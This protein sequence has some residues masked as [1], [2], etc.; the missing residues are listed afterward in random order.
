MACGPPSVLFQPHVKHRNQSI[1]T[2]IRSVSES[3]GCTVNRLRLGVDKGACFFEL[4]DVDE[5][6]SVKEVL[7]PLRELVNIDWTV[8]LKCSLAS[9]P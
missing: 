8:S 9:W 3:R 7:V 2:N 5:N 4:P 6:G 1:P